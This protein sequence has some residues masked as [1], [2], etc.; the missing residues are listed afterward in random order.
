[1]F[2]I[3]SPMLKIA[4]II[5][6][7]SLSTCASP[8]IFVDTLPAELPGL[9]WYRLL[10]L[11]R[12]SYPTCSFRLMQT[13]APIISLLIFLENYFKDSFTASCTTFPDCTFNPLN[14][15]SSSSKALSVPL[16]AISREYLLQNYF[17]L[18]F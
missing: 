5:F 13:T 15:C 10:L 18:K 16:F 7:K 11:V 9:G 3:F 6:L 2:G 1:M 4:S 12:I 14:K 17:C 8:I